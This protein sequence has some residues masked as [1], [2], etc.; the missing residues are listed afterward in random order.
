MT[1]STEIDIYAVGVLYELRFAYSA[2][3][4]GA[5]MEALG[6]L[7]RIPGM[8]GRRS[9]WNGYLAEPRDSTV[10][11]TECGH[12]WTRRRALA[13]LARNIESGGQR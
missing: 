7:K 1:E 8:W 5:W 13:R 10:E 12:G 9:S 2:A 11:I 3:R 6:R 4:H